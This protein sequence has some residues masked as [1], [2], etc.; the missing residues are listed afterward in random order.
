MTISYRKTAPW[1][2]PDPSHH[3]DQGTTIRCKKPSFRRFH[4]PPF[5]PPKMNPGFG[6]QEPFPS[7]N[8]VHPVHGDFEAPEMFAMGDYQQTFDSGNNREKRTRTT[9]YS[10]EP[11]AGGRFVRANLVITERGMSDGHDISDVLD[12]LFSQNAQQAGQIQYMQSQVQ[13]VTSINQELR[14]MVNGLKQQM[15][16]VH[17]QPDASSN[18]KQKRPSK[19]IRVSVY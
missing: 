3:A 12:A 11:R 6:N 1:P 5:H 4:L 16:V 19:E 8:P 18:L 17:A 10:E 7:T 14:G 2:D 9:S 15:E 13:D